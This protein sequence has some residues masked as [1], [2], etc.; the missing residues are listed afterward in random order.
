VTQSVLLRPSAEFDTRHQSRRDPGWLFVG[1]GHG[2]ERGSWSSQFVQFAAQFRELF[3]VK[4]AANVTDKSKFFTLI[5]T[6]Q[7]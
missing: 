7:Q 6:Q 2:V 1:F 5:Q 4:S 3:R